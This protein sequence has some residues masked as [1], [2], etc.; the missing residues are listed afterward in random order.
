M[1]ESEEGVTGSEGRE[2]VTSPMKLL[3]NKVYDMDLSH[4]VLVHT[5]T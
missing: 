5:E 2:R 3:L 1:L 4:L